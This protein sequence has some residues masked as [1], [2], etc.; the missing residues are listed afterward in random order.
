[1]GRSVLDLV[2]GI[3]LIVIGILLVLGKLG[4]EG[5]LPYA[6]IVLIVLG[7]LILL[8]TAPG[9]NLIGIVVLVVGIL[10][11]A[12]FLPLPKEIREW[13]WI[14]NLVMGIVLIALGAKK[15]MRG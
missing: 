1:M 6:G 5:L 7:I 8:G 14:V 4:I 12:G 2:V 3:G 13:M 11:V 10:L 15:L 9:G